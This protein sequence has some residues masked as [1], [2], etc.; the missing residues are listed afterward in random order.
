MPMHLDLLSDNLIIALK[1][2]E[3]NQNL[4]KLIYYSDDDPLDQPDLE[5]PANK[6]FLESLFP[7]RFDPEVII[8]DCTQLRVWYPR[9]DFING[10]NINIS[11]IY[12]SIVLAKSL[13]MIHVNNIPKV[14]PY[15]II[16]EVYK[17]FHEKS[18]GTLGR[19]HFKNFILYSVNKQFDI[20]EIEAEM[21]AL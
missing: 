13:Y 8:D 20:F 4:C 18:L 16:D 1:Q 15:S 11:R 5:L 17:T 7:Y 3:N 14:R 21:M 6:L 2:V 19:I 9:G 10:E 12:F